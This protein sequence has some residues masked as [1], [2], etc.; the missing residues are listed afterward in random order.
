MKKHSRLLR[1]WSVSSTW[2]PDHSTT[3]VARSAGAA[4]YR[5]WLKIVDSW[6]EMPFT[7]MRARAAP[8]YHEQPGFR[9]CMIYR[10]I[11]FAQLGMRVRFDDGKMGTLVGH[12]SSAN[13]DV[14]M[15]GDGEVLNCHPAWQLSYCVDGEWKRS[16]LAAEAAA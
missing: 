1:S 4:K 7:A 15:D 6:S 3:V 10:G 11:P 2:F 13:L 14:I 5:Q 16:T 9:D 8:G 12:N